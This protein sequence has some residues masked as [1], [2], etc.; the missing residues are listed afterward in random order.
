MGEE[1]RGR[2]EGVVVVDWPFRRG[3]EMGGIST[4]SE[5]LRRWTGFAGV[6]R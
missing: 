5:R 3:A 2:T 4:A 1:F 6:L